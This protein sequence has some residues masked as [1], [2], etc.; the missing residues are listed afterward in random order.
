MAMPSHENDIIV[1]RHGPRL[2][3]SPWTI[4]LLH[5][6]DTATVAQLMPHG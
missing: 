1:A 6:S 4:M 5:V 3:T 2:E